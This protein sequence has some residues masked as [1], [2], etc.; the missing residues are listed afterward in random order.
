[1]GLSLAL[2]GCGSMGSALLKGWLTLPKS[3]ID[4]KTF[5]IIAPHREKAEPYLTDSRLQWI[6]SPEQL[7]YDPDRIVFALKPFIL[8]EILPLYKPYKSLIISVAAGKPLSF[9]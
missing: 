2:V 7:P 8:K 5:W 1:M 3:K 6:S 4:F 9:Y